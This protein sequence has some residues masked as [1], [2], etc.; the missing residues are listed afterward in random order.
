MRSILKY[1]WGK[2][3]KKIILLLMLSGLPFSSFGMEYIKGYFSKKNE[4]PVVEA[5]QPIKPSMG[6]IYINPDVDFK[7]VMSALVLAAK[8]KEIHGI[9]LV[10]DNSGGSSSLFS[11]LHDLIK[12][13]TLIKPVVALVVGGAFSGGYMIASAANYIIASSCAGIGSIGA[14]MEL[15]KLKDAKIMGDVEAKMDI[16]LIQAGEYKTITHAYKELS[17]H[18]RDYLQKAMNKLYKQFVHMVAV[19]RTLNEETY[20]EW[21]DAKFF[22]A[23]EA[24]ELGLVDEIGTMF[25]AES[26][27]IEL[28]SKKSPDSTFDTEI[29]QVIFS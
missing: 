27:M 14:V 6:I 12:R 3:M 13:I 2:L 17:D 1:I 16:E 11:A 26:K 4:A 5:I 19:N 21:A 28:I 25:E 24:L 10:I 8:N 29:D 20:L 9:L 23:P 15:Q 18:Q 7:Q 22:L